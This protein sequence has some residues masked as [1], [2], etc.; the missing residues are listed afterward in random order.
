MTALLTFSAIS[1]AAEGLLLELP[2]TLRSP[3]IRCGGAAER[4]RQ[5]PNLFGGGA[6]QRPGKSCLYQ[7]ALALGTFCQPVKP[8]LWNPSPK[9][10]RRWE[11]ATFRRIK[12]QIARAI[13]VIS[14]G[15]TAA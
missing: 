8:R 14:A 5:P 12:G 9:L 3:R 7:C 13:S 1:S 15:F 10:K 11:F 2:Q 6:L 4:R